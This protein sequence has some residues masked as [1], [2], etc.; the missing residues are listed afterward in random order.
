MTVYHTIG[1]FSRLTG[2]SEKALR[3][4]DARG[5][6]TPA[7]VD[8]ATGYRR[9]DPDQVEAGRMIAL[10]RAIDMPLAEIAGVIAHPPADRSAAVGDYWY[11]VERDLDDRRET[12]REA[13]QLSQR[14]ARGLSHAAAVSGGGRSEG[15]F[16]AIGRL[17]EIADPLEAAPAYVS[18]MRTAY[19]D[20]KDLPLAVAIALAG[21][22]RLLADTHRALPEGADALRS[23]VKGLLYDLASFTW[24][25]WGAAGIVVSPVHTALG[26][27][28]AEANLALAEEL[29]KGEL[30][31]ARAH[32]M[33]GAHLL[34]SGSPDVAGDEFRAAASLAE[35]AGSRPEVLLAE[36]FAALART[37]TG[38]EAAE[39]MVTAV[40]A[41]L[42]ELEGGEM[43]V[44]Q[45]VTA[46][47]ALS[48]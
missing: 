36:G 14:T 40:L 15:T 28:A 3:L 20:D 21:I 18:A 44:E 32:W 22:G 33:L 48:V 7:E 6:L 31:R 19:W 37:A 47:T 1:E 2:L 26:L 9:Y 42:A 41:Q 12:V 34:S 30:A 27:A 39:G 8:P 29:G 35:A 17:A 10:L 23:T 45:I 5:L 16:A 25:G 24:P 38:D 43:F 4:Y 46:R 11:R 13:R